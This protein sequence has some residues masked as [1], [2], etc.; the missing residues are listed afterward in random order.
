LL[1][2]GSYSDFQKGHGNLL[3]KRAHEAR[4]SQLLGHIKRANV[5]CKGGKN[6]RPVA[7]HWQTLS[8]NQIVVLNTPLAMSGIQSH[9]ISGDSHWFLK[10]YNKLHSRQYTIWIT[11]QPR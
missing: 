3:W 6:H 5:F 8:H 4:E 10:L 2:S 11:E 7:S 1:T 9:N